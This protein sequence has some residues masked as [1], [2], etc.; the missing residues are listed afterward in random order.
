MSPSGPPRY[1]STYFAHIFGSP[2]GY[3]ADYY[4]YTWS[5]VLARD[6]EHW[7]NAHG[8]LKRE[9]GALLRNKV[10][11]RGFSADPLTMFKDFYGKDPEIGPL[12]EARVQG[13]RA[14]LPAR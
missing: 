14:V 7:F 9:N 11:S 12:L 10:L 13:A 6:T 5:E 1:R 3:T 4:A 2:T 8:G